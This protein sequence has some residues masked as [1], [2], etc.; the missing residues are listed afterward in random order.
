MTH[1]IIILLLTAAPA[2]AFDLLPTVCI[3]LVLKKPVPCSTVDVPGPLGIAGA[4]MAWRAS[5]RIRRRLA[6]AAPV[7]K[8]ERDG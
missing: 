6:A 3:D 1:I 7:A 2:Q 4:A 5:R 8:P